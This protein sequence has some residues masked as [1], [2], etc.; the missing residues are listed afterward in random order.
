MHLILT[1][2]IFLASDILILTIVIAQGSELPSMRQ[3]LL[4]YYIYRA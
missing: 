1:L 3:R 4:D 2:I